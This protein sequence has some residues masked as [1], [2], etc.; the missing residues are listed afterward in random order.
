MTNQNE[1]RNLL[2]LR[3]Y[4]LG[5]FA[6]AAL[7]LVLVYSSLLDRYFLWGIDLR[8]EA[9]LEQTADNYALARIENITAPLPSGQNT[10]AYEEMSE[11]PNNFQRLFSLDSP[12][13]NQLFRYLNIDFDDDTP[14]RM[15]D[16]LNLCDDTRCEIVFLYTYQLENDSWL[17]LVHGLVGSDEIYREIESNEKIVFTLGVALILIFLALAFF[18]SHII[19]TPLRRLEAWSL[20]LS[21]DNPDRDIGNLRFQE[22]DTLARRLRYA[23]ERMNQSIEG[24]KMFLQ[25]ASHELRTPLA[26]LSTN[27]ELIERLTEREHRSESERAAF[28]RQYQ[29]LSDVQLLIETL[30]WINR[31]STNLPNSEHVNLRQELDQIVEEQQHLIEKRLVSFTIDGENDFVEAPVAAV[32]IVLSNLIR[33]AFQYTA[34]GEI[35]IKIE[36]RSIT[37]KNTPADSDSLSEFN[38]EYGFGFG[39]ELVTRICRNLHWQLASNEQDGARSVSVKFGSKN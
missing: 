32:R 23:F 30:L 17:Y 12:K 1:I 26:I 27:V 38:H 39:L 16:T 31:Q 9:L 11:I 28:L 29:A 8:T 34:D 15:I 14:E 24:E 3:W 22:L 37:I 18:S 35:S 2:P 20:S 5:W 19:N 7:I 36:P 6:V 4:L 25:H 13:T 33:N 10:K 21:A